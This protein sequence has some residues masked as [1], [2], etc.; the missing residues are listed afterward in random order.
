MEMGAVL[1]LLETD[2]LHGPHP[3]DENGGDHEDKEAD[4]ERAGV[5]GKDMPPFQSYFG[6][7]NEIG[8]FRQL[9]EA[10]SLLQPTDQQTEHITQGDT[11][12]GDIAAF[13]QKD[14]LYRC[15]EGPKGFED[16]DHV[17]ALE[18]EDDETG[19]QIEDRDD[20]HDDDDDGDRFI[21]QLQPVEDIGIGFFGSPALPFFR[22]PVED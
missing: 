20:R 13:V 8:F 21:L 17:R 15:V 3:A 4:E 5:Y 19:D 18:H 2:R 9:Y 16:T 10:E 6:L 7:G 12:K 11:D 22:E 14:D 1:E